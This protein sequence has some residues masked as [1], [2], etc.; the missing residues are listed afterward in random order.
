[1]GKGQNQPGP[2]II[3]TGWAQDD[4]IEICRLLNEENA[5]RK[6]VCCC[7]CHRQ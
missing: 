3:A 2:L 5:R 7:A 1:M 4:M 6:H